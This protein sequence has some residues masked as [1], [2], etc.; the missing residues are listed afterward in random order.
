[1]KEPITPTWAAT[2]TYDGAGRCTE[3]IQAADAETACTELMSRATPIYN[4]GAECKLVGA[5]RIL[6]FEE[7]SALPHRG[8]ETAVDLTWDRRDKGGRFLIVERGSAR[9]RD[10]RDYWT[11]VGRIV[12]SVDSAAA[13]EKL[14]QALD[15]DTRKRGYSA[16]FD[17]VPRDAVK[18]AESGQPYGCNTGSY[19]A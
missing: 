11:T 19:T 18:L 5:H 14:V 9:D 4:P 3:F 1:M 2:Y 10:G 15:L 8:V 7:L 16:L 6:F 17:L 12:R 13:G